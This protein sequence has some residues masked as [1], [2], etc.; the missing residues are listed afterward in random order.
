MVGCDH[1]AQNGKNLG[2]GKVGDFTR[3]LGHTL[4][5]RWVLDVG[6]CRRPVVCFGIGC[7]NSLPLFVAFEDVSILFQERFA[8]HSFLNQCVDLSRC[9]PDVFQEDVV[10]VLVLTKCFGGQIDIHC[11]SQ[12]VGD[13]ERGR[14]EVV[15]TDVR[16]NPT[17]KV[18]VTRQ[19]RC[20]HEIAFDNRVGQFLLDRPR[21][22]DAGRAAIT[23][24]VEPKF[25]EVFLQASGFE[26]FGHNL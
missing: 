24:K 15:C 18:P 12:R 20:R 19:H 13:D 1:I 14:R 9:W 5:I 21:V 3:V 6:R 2:T 17:F 11:P 10:A 25:V 22:A 16:R 4:E 23:D 7:L 26:I 8:G